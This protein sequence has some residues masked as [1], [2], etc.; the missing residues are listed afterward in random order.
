MIYKGRNSKNSNSKFQGR[1]SRGEIPVYK[2]QI[3]NAGA[4]F[5][6]WNF[7][8]WNLLF[9]LWNFIFHYF[10]PA[11]LRHAIIVKRAVQTAITAAIAA[12]EVV[13]FG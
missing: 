3:P 11:G 4:G 1:N 6:I 12:V 5:G 13:L 7:F 9:S 2:F 8:I 10:T